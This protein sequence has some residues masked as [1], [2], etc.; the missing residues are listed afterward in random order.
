MIKN[1]INTLSL[2]LIALLLASFGAF[3]DAT[4]DHHV[5]SV[6]E[7]SSN[8]TISIYNTG[9]TLNLEDTNGLSSDFRGS[10]DGP[11]DQINS[12]DF[13]LG[14]FVKQLDVKYK[15][16]AEDGV[17]LLSVGKMPT[18][19]KTNISSPS[20]LGGVMG[21]RL[22]IEPEKIPL[23][24]DW[25]T[26]NHL[27]I[28]R[29]EVT[30]YN[31]ESGD[32]LDLNDLNKSNMTSYA[33]YLSKNENIQTFFVYKTPDEDNPFGVTSK[34]LGAVYIMGGKL[35]PQLFAMTHTSKASF[36]DL[37]LLVLSASIEV[38][39]NFRMTFTY[40]HAIETMSN[41]NVE[42]YDVSVTREFKKTK[43][44]TFA[45]TYGVKVEEGTTENRVLYFRL[46]AKF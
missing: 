46:E 24:Q 31:A 25:L 40:D 44:F 28:D 13:D 39:P 5:T 4:F 6:I 22:S 41:A 29:I 27:K 10:I 7:A 2:C 30:R 21:I 38:L 42:D 26:Q 16:K 11:V 43:D 12:K 33:V 18:G 19:A 8:D 34:T 9:L 36:M 37:D 45:T 15:I 20:K 17:I 35:K 3:A 1:T 23:I 32:S 14:K